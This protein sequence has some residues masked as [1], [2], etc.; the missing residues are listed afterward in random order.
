MSEQEST[1]LGDATDALRRYQ[2]ELDVID[3]E[4]SELEQVDSRF[5]IARVALFFLAIA[6]WLLAAFGD[7]SRVVTVAGWVAF[8]GFLGVA[9]WNESYRDRLSQ[10]KRDRFVFRRLMARLNRDWETL[11]TKRL[12]EKLGEITLTEEQKDVADDLDLLGRMSLFHFVSITA[13]TIGIRTLAQW[14]AGPAQASVASQRHRA[15][16]SLAPLRKERVRFYALAR[17]IGESSG[18]PDRFTTW[19]VGPR[20]L[21]SRS[22]LLTWANLSVVVTAILV[23]AIFLGLFGVLAVSTLKASALALFGVAV[24][25]FLGTGV[26]LGPAHEVFSIA[27]TTRQ[28]VSNYQ[29]L[30]AAAQQLPAGESSDDVL[31]RIRQVILDD[32]QCASVG[33]SALQRIAGAGSLRQ[34]GLGFFLYLPLQAFGLWDV[35][36][37]R[38]LEEWQEQFGKHVPSWFEALG[39]LEALMSIAAL[40]DDY[41]QWAS[42]QWTDSEQLQLRSI[43]LGHP[44][45]KDTDRVCNDVSVGPPGTIL[46][47]TGSNMSG[48]STMLRSVGLN[49]ALAGIGAPVC[50]E[51]FKLPSIQLATSIR[52]RDNLG[53][54]V[55]FYMAELQRLKSVVDQAKKFAT[56]DQIV[57]LF[58]L[59]EILQGTNSRERQIAVVQVLRHLIRSQSIG[60]ISTHDLE[61]AD[62]ADLQ[63]VAQTVHFRETIRPDAEGNEQMTFDYQMR[64]GVSPTTNALRLLELVGLGE[65]SAEREDSSN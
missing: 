17:E 53:E 14:L 27:M 62:D 64:D 9:I 25:N 10:L 48:K 21:A 13:T 50:A 4:C 36:V 39:E 65:D 6:L 11:A 41:P 12:T 61:L 63:S 18:D 31:R 32:S 43:S 33:M 29:E 58:L 45:L 1:P 44:L 5:G 23:A 56:D 52:V 51:S 55:S 16:K 57:L 7:V 19:A 15:V 46:L 54:G 30:F 28:S 24:L 35:R 60:A 37:L 8:F 59:D 2:S 40:A 42:P 34:S 26:V 22:W 3:Q 20:W 49:V 38:R 47:V